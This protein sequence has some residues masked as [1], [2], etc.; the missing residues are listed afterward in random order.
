MCSPLIASSIIGGASALSSI[1]GQRYQAQAQ[2][3][4]QRLASMQERQRYQAEVAAMRT[5]QQQEQ[6]GRT[7]QKQQ[8]DKKAMEARATATVSAGEAGVSGLS[9]DA[10]L[11]DISR[12]QA[13]F[14][15]SS[16]RQAAMTD[17]N[18]DLALRESGMGFNR[19]MLRINQPIQQP[20]YL[21]SLVGGM[22]TG[23]STYGVLDDSGLFKQNKPTG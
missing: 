19:S 16:D 10:L 17:V 20:D 23:L 21:G 14:N 4:S 11:G 1:Q 5:Q 18:R 3:E 13:E 12:Q 9:V 22:Q 2:A 6:E 8:A 15:F 7:Q